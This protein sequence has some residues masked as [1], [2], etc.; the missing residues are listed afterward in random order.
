MEK[1]KLGRQGLEVPAVGLG[2]MGMSWAYG[3]ADEADSIRVLHRALDLGVN[4]WDT[5]EMYGPFTNEEL[6]GKAILGRRRQ[7]VIVATKFAMKFGSNLEPSGSTAVRRTS[8]GPSR[9]RYAGWERITSISIT[10]IAWIR[11]PR[12]KKPSA[13][14]RLS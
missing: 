1:R 4:F 12:S 10:S 3:G 9:V 14:W 8:N 5:A 13:R 2:C 6:V 7:D 11:R